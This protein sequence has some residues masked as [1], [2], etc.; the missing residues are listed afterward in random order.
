MAEPS[1]RP[2]SAQQSSGLQPVHSLRIESIRKPQDGRRSQTRLSWYLLAVGIGFT[3]L[4]AVLSVLLTDLGAWGAAGLTLVA[5]IFQVLGVVVATR[6]GPAEET[7]RHQLFSA[8]RMFKRLDDLRQQ[9]EHEYE[10]GNAET[11]RKH[12]GK[13]SAAFTYLQDSAESNF[14]GWASIYPDLVDSHEV[15]NDTKET[16]DDA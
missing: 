4:L 3:I 16:A 9:T 15:N 8:L 1:R 10:A 7:V 14:Y 6:T 13:V 2:S 5:G 11:R 12:L